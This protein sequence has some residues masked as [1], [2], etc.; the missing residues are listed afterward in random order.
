LQLLLFYHP[1]K[2]ILKE[3][4]LDS[5]PEVAVFTSMV[6]LQNCKSQALI[7]GVRPRVEDEIIFKKQH[8]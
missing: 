6:G 1:V 5:V 7:A 8:W 2:N 3:S 4:R